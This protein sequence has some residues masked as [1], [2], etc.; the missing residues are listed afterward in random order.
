[1]DGFSP[2]PTSFSGKPIFIDDEIEIKVFSFV[3]IVNENGKRRIFNE[4]ILLLTNFRIIVTLE[5]SSSDKSSSVISWGLNLSSIG[6]VEDSGSF[7]SSNSSVKLKLIPTNIVLIIKLSSGKEMFKELL[8]KQLIKKAWEP[9]NSHVSDEVKFSPTNAGVG[10]LLRR[11]EKDISS[12]DNITRRAL[13]DLDSLMQSAKEVI[14]VVQWYAKLVQDNSG[15]AMSE[16]STEIG[17]K[18][19]M[20]TIL[21]NIGIISPVT[22][23]SAG[24]LYHRELSR[25]L[26]DFLLTGN[27]LR[28][29]GGIAALTDVYC[30]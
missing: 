18:N 25:Q 19:E 15:D 23:F 3:E 7:F 16:T 8:S 22:K 30:I 9:K 10:G 29:M 17:E 27:L 1:M 5:V 26:G 12:A 4:G 24:R 11:Q 6:K 21:Q 28:K 20:E 14:E 2:A 13:T